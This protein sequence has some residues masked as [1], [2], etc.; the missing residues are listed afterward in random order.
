MDTKEG[1]DLESR[2]NQQLDI[3]HEGKTRDL[4]AKTLLIFIQYAKGEEEIQESTLSSFSG[5]EQLKELETTADIVFFKD[6]PDLREKVQP[7]N[8]RLA[9]NDLPS[10]PV[11]FFLYLLALRDW[12]NCIDLSSRPGKCPIPERLQRPTLKCP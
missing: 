10:Y 11:F 5:N 6:Q 8:V 2:L 4:L 7:L 12:V 3:L 1:Q 9:G